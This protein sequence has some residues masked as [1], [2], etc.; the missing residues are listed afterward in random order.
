MGSRKIQLLADL[1]L[2]FVT[3]VWGATFV[4]VKEAIK[5]IE[6]FY[7]LAIRFGIATLIMLVVTNKRIVR[8][9]TSS[10]LK[11]VL[12]GLMLFAGY[13]FQ[14]FGLRY[15]SA[16]NAGFI[17]GL[18]VVFVPICIAMATKKLPGIISALGIVSATLGLGLLTVSESLNINFGDILVLFC[19]ISYTFHI[20]LLGRYSPDNDTFILATV[21]IATVAAASYFS[22]LVKE[23]APSAANFDTEVWQ[24]ILITAVLATAL[25]FFMQ[26]WTQKYTSP[27][28]TAII[29][30]TE[31]VFAALFA[32]LIG[33]ESFTL[34]QGL[35]AVFILGGMLASELG[36]GAAKVEIAE[37]TLKV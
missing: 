26:T 8:L 3:L 36:S 6:P 13:A 25:A 14:T 32:Y 24:A 20:L 34:R 9:T 17:T 37:D 1:A 5:H 30:T 18:S 28:H 12:I 19:A 10:F 33:G 23:T 27:T 29:F 15:T 21:Q 16:S 4:T 7:F 2:V 35:G 11:G 22:A 31:P